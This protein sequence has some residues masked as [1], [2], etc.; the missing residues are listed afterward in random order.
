MKLKEN[1]L[2]LAVLLLAI[3][4]AKGCFENK[5]LKSEISALKTRD[6]TNESI[7]NSLSNL[8]EEEM[9]QRIE[10]VKQVSLS[11]ET[12]SIEDNYINLAK[13][14][15][16]DNFVLKSKEDY[17]LI[18]QPITGQVKDTLVGNLKEYLRANPNSNLTEGVSIDIKKL[19]S[20]LEKLKFAVGD[21]M[22]ENFEFYLGQGIYTNEMFGT[23][24]VEQNN[25]KLS[26]FRKTIIQMRTRGQLNPTTEPTSNDQEKLA[27]ID[28]YFINRT[29]TFL[30]ILKK[31]DIP[32]S[33]VRD[34]NNREYS[35]IFDV[36]RPCPPGCPY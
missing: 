31:G 26:H 33:A 17:T 1:I 6:Y 19:I 35:M 27:I 18:N 7:I 34:A 10:K 5:E 2:L 20:H 25:K 13:S 9:V 12:E 23:T 4:L 22:E 14:L 15:L 32:I 29:T 3:F 21:V 11:E 30:H 36:G 24:V 8:S 28:K 16:D